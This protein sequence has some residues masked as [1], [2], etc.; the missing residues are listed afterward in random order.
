MAGK[1]T[2]EWLYI[3]G[4]IIAVLAGL[5]AVTGWT[6]PWIWVLLVVIGIVVGLLNISE[7]ESNDFL[8]A[9]VALVVAGTVGFT[10]LNTAVMG[11]GTLIDAIVKNIAVMVAPAAVITAVKA[12]HGLASKK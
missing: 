11:L 6:N 12:V 2:S 10:A 8:V 3:I 9:S 1:S 5:A 4:V 7:K